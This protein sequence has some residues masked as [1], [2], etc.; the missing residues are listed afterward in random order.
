MN[1]LL[2]ITIYAD[3]VDDAVELDCDIAEID[4]LYDASIGVSYSAVDYPTYTGEM[5]FTP[6]E[7]AQIIHTKETRVLQNITIN[8]IPQNYGKITWNGSILTVS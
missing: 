1:E 4:V 7:E 3:I 2:P 6:T 5:I 8:P